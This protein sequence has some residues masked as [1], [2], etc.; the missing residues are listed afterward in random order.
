MYGF[1]FFTMNET[2]VKN[3]LFFFFEAYVPSI[4]LRLFVKA[5]T[6]INVFIIF[7]ICLK[8]K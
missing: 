3:H 5:K 8:E 6:E 2:G 4:V 7:Q 1:F